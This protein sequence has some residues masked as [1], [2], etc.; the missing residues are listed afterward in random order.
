MNVSGRLDQ[1][2]I[3]IWE[4]VQELLRNAFIEAVFPGF[5]SDVGRTTR[6]KPAPPVR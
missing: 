2:Q 5:E 6:L 4:V 1:P 3:R